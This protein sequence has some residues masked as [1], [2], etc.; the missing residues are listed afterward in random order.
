MIAPNDQPMAV[1]SGA[2]DPRTNPAR[3]ADTSIIVTA[4]N[5]TTPGAMIVL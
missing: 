1:A 4:D 3:P 2:P 5:A